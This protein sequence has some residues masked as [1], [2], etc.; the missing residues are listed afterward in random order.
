MSQRGPDGDRRVR[1]MDGKDENRQSSDTSAN[2]AVQLG[3]G[4]IV[5]LG[6]YGLAQFRSSEEPNTTS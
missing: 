1:I 4:D 2:D 3:S 6:T 5:T